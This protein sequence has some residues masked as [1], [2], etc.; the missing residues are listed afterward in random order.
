MK[1]TVTYHA[2]ARE[3]VGGTER[4]DVHLH[5]T[6]GVQPPATRHLRALLLERHHALKELLPT[7]ALAVNCVYAH[8]DTVLKDGDEVAVLPPVSGG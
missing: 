4:E 3:R 6:D 5:P 2:S 7:C 1:I 8:D